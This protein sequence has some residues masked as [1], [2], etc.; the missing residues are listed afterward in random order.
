MA[1]GLYVSARGQRP[2]GKTCPP[3]EI[4]IRGTACCMFRRSGYPGTAEGISDH[5]KWCVE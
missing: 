2:S 3:Y 1:D 4:F 5:S